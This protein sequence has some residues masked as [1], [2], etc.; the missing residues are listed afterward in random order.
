[1]K[2]FGCL[3]Q[4]LG[5]DFKYEDDCIKMNQAKCVE[6]ILE[7]FGMSDCKPKSTPCDQAFVKLEFDDSCELTDPKLYKEIVGSLIYG[8]S[9]ARPDITYVVTKLPQ[10]MN[11]PTQAYLNAAKNVLRYLKYTREYCLK[12]KKSVSGIEL[13]GYTNRPG[14]SSIYLCE[15]GKKV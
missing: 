4:F 1:M 5:I 8:M 10:Y 14:A 2:D 11:N 6:R 7:R 9:C 13:I 12:F 15:R 3:T